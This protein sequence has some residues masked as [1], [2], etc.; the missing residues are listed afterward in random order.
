M[1]IPPF[2]NVI[3]QSFHSFSLFQWAIIISLFLAPIF[4]NLASMGTS[5]NWSPVNLTLP[6]LFWKNFFFVQQEVSD[7][8][9]N[10]LSQYE[11]S[12]TTIEW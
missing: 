10:S 9:W 11:Y 7:S 2:L 4:H 8:S 5:L 1:L 12:L 6:H 3:M